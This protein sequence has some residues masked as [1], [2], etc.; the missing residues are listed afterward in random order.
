MRIFFSILFCI[1]MYGC[2]PRQSFFISPNNV[3]KKE[4]IV[5]MDDASVKKGIISIAFEN[6]HER[7]NEM[8]IKADDDTVNEKLDVKK[9]RSY[10]I[11]GHTY[12]VKIINLYL[13]SEYHY[14]FVE[15]L[16]NENDKMQLYKL[17]PPE[18]T[19]VSGL[20]P[21]YYYISF[22]AFGEYQV[23]DINSE[24][25]V[26][27]FDIKMASYL[28]D[29][30]DLQD[31]VRSKQKNYYYTLFSLGAIRIEIIKNIVKEYN[32]CK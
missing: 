1:S 24:K 10:T 20:D 25:L 14:L 16:T 22:P 6:M 17:I 5:Y 18:N 15:R 7:D 27:L 30:P 19:N 32:E 31:K 3:Y 12:V 26:P 9:I 21:Y 13:G 29:C 2:T 11:D 8:S 23:I 4:G 28:K